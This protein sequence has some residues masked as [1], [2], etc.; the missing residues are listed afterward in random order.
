MKYI[1][2]LLF[3]LGIIIFRKNIF[4][5][6]C[7]PL[8]YQLCPYTNEYAGAMC[9]ET[10][11]TAY[12]DEYYEQV[13]T[14]IPPEKY[15]HSFWGTVKIDS[16]RILSVSNIPNF[17]SFQCNT[18]N[19]TFKAGKRYCLKIYGLPDS[20]SVGIYHPNVYYKAWVKVYGFIDKI[21]YDNDSSLTFIVEKPL[22]LKNYDFENFNLLYNVNSHQ[23]S[24]IS[25]E[26]INCFIEIFDISGKRILFLNKNLEKGM[27]QVCNIENLSQGMYFLR[28]IANGKVLFKRIVKY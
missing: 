17:L 21:I 4:S 5:Q 6:V 12:V 15:R 2:Q 28:I 25:L 7:I 19:C 16:I 24:I 23:I 13:I 26:Q 14:I 3:L 22:N 8:S 1:F 20:S 18:N 27:N 9:P 11:P 10:L